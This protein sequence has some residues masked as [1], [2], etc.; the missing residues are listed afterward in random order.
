MQAKLDH[1]FSLF[2][3]AYLKVPSTT[4]APGAILSSLRDDE[5]HH[6]NDQEEED[7]ELSIQC[8][9]PYHRWFCD[10]SWGT[11][12]VIGGVK[13][14]SKDQNKTKQCIYIF[15]HLFAIIVLLYS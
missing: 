15:Y 2:E 6:H 4:D 14:L 12:L 1:A 10:E 7:E 8:V 3:A 5:S 13:L 9:Y 11:M